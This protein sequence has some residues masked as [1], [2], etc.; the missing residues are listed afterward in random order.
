MNIVID[1]SLV[2]DIRRSI[3]NGFGL[4][5]LMNK[6]DTYL[7]L[8]SSPRHSSQAS[9]YVVSEPQIPLFSYIGRLNEKS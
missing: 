8:N 4:F 7:R 6:L 3:K 5:Q 1:I 2:K 9:L